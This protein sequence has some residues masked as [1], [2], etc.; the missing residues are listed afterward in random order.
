MNFIPKPLPA[1]AFGEML[2]TNDQDLE[3]YKLTLR[4]AIPGLI[5]L[6]PAGKGAFR[7]KACGAR[8]NGMPVVASAST[9]T[10]GFVAEMTSPVVQVVLWGRSSL[11]SGAEHHLF[12][13]G[14][15]AY[16]PEAA[17][18]GECDSLSVLTMAVDRRRLI[19]AYV[20]VAGLPPGPADEAVLGRTKVVPPGPLSNRIVEKIVAVSRVIDLSLDN[21]RALDALGLDDVLHRLVAMVLWPDLLE[22]RSED[23]GAHETGRSRFALMQDFIRANLAAPIRVTVLAR[24]AGVSTRLVHQIFER[25]VGVSPAQ[26]IRNLRLEEAHRLL[27]EPHGERRVRTIAARCGFIKP[28]LFTAHYRARF[29]ETP[30][31]TLKRR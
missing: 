11:T 24:Q 3:A 20:A 25:E 1:L 8:I 19:D 26:W 16:I 2:A 7:F 22:K 15:I 4:Q 10:S 14:T 21:Q 18:L 12:S 29:G 28:A 13:P 5:R 31:E 9:P 30:Q 6:D 17:R 27:R 23:A